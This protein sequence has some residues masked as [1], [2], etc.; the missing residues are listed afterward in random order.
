MEL[1]LSYFSVV[2]VP[3]KMVGLERMLGYR[4]VR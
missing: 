2:T 4:V 3:Q 1:L